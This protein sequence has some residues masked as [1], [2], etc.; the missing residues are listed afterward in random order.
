MKDE[1][2]YNQGDV[3]TNPDDG[4]VPMLK[5]HEAFAGVE[6]P[7]YQSVINHVTAAEGLLRKYS[8]LYTQGKEQDEPAAAGM[9]KRKPSHAAAQHAHRSHARTLIPSSAHARPARSFPP[10]HCRRAA[11]RQP[12]RVRPGSQPWHPCVCVVIRHRGH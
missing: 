5:K 9:Y 6:M 4:I 2:K 11:P 7:A 12:L 3:W 1:E 10:A 8:H